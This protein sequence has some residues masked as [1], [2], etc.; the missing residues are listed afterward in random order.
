MQFNL[1]LAVLAS[2]G[3]LAVA[4]GEDDQPKNSGC[5]SSGATHGSNYNWASCNPQD[6]GKSGTIFGGDPDPK[7]WCYV[8]SSDKDG[9]PALCGQHL[10][11][12]ATCLTKDDDSDLGG[13][14]PSGS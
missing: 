5:F 12:N 8:K 4:Q 2:A 1:V 11:D 3:I 6:G 14:G 7:N 9:L 13:C 10:D